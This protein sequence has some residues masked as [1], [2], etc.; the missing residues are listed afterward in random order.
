LA[1][2]FFLEEDAHVVDLYD[3]LR[4]HLGHLQAPGYTF[5][6]SFMLEAGQRLPD[7]CPGD[8]EAL[9]Q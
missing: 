5:Q 6:E 9:S 4:V 7:G 1:G 3:L 8:A 2:G